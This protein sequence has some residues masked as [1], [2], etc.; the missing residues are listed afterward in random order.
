MTDQL[1]MDEVGFT[2]HDVLEGEQCATLGPAYFAARR[3]SE[4]IMAKMEPDI[5]EPLIKQF[6]DAL[7]EKA[8]EA[9]TEH[10]LYDAEQNVQ[11]GI[12]RMVDQT[13]T[14]LLTGS[15]WALERY[16]LAKYHDGQAVRK[17]IFEQCAD[18]MQNMRIVELEAEV[19]RLKQINDFYRR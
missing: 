15:E 17:A 9:F 7:Y 8:S 14:A 16:P 11:G 1:T 5:L 19:E 2:P 3:M 18:R 10:L 12:W 13:V 4:T 6:S